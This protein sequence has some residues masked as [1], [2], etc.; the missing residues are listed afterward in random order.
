MPEMTP[1]Q[2]TESCALLLLA[3]GFKLTSHA[4]SW[5]D[6]GGPENGP[7]LVGHNAYDEYSDGK[8]S[9][10]VEGGEIKAVEAVPPD[11]G[12]IPF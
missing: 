9:V 4:A 2:F 10:F 6:V 7:K 8:T 1:I 11:F 3:L 12:D 5:E